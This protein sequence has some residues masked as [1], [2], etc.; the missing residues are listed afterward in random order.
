V[1]CGRCTRARDLYLSTA[2]TLSVVLCSND[3][4]ATEAPILSAPQMRPDQRPRARYRWKTLVSAVAAAGVVIAILWLARTS[5]M[6]HAGLAVLSESD[7][8]RI[9]LIDRQHAIVREGSVEL[10]VGDEDSIVDTPLGVVRAKNAKLRIAATPQ[11]ES[12]EPDQTQA[13]FIVTIAVTSGLARWSSKDEHDVAIGE[14]ETLVRPRPSSSPNPD[15]ESGALRTPQ[16]A[17]AARTSAV[18]TTNGLPIDIDPTLAAKIGYR[19]RGHVIDKSNGAPIDGAR[20]HFVTM[21]LPEGPWLEAQGR[22]EENGYFALRCSEVEESSLT[23]DR[24]IRANSN[25]PEGLDVE[26]DEYGSYRAPLDAPGLKLGSPFDFGAIALDRGLKLSGRIIDATGVPVAGAI[27]FAGHGGYASVW[28]TA[29]EVGNSDHAGQIMLR[30]RLSGYDGVVLVAV[31]DRGLGWME[32]PIRDGGSE[33]LDAVMQLQPTAKLV[34]CVRD[35]AGLPIA[36]AAVK[37]EP[38]FKPFD[39]FYRG[40]HTLDVEVIPVACSIFTGKT[41]GAGNLE[42]PFLPSPKEYSAYEIGVEHYGFTRSVR[43][44]DALDPTRTSRIEITMPEYRRFA[45]SGRVT[46][47]AGQPIAGARV[48]A[49]VTD[50]DGRYRVTNLDPSQR[51]VELTYS[52]NG[53]IPSTRRVAS[54]PKADIEGFDVVLDAPMSIDGHIVDE[55]GARVAGARVMLE[56]GRSW[57]RM[58]NRDERTDVDGNFSF[59]NSTAGEWNVVITG[60]SPEDAWARYDGPPVHGGD[61]GV[62]LVLH[63]A[64]T[65]AQEPGARVTAEI[66]DAETHQPIDPVHVAILSNAGDNPFPQP[67]PLG[68]EQKLGVVSIAYVPRGSWSL[69]ISA[70]AGRYASQCFTVEPARTEVSLTIVV[71]RPSSI[72]GTIMFGEFERSQP[73]TVWARLVPQHHSPDWLGMPKSYSFGEID[74]DAAFQFDNLVAGRWRISMISK[75][76]IAER[77]L[78]IVPGQTAEVELVCQPAAHI[79]FSSA[80]PSA[81]SVLEIHLSAQGGSGSLDVDD[82]EPAKN[83]H[84]TARISVCSGRYRWTATW[85]NEHDAGSSTQDILSQSG[86]V[87]VAAGAT[88]E[89]ELTVIHK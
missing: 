26:H 24:A 16:Q 60:P 1:R 12:V 75:D 13:A 27:L 83:G 38:K 57:V 3:P 17:D 34:V 22:S 72:R 39:H 40:T 76:L 69:W 33:W 77:E 23:G 65:A 6:R 53:F 2:D 51:Q 55:L 20:V 87:E 9:E 7:D 32:L 81:D 56:R 49:A 86:D 84:H 5:V 80:A 74:A 58:S 25:A 29:H 11:G 46:D 10:E 66:V 59:K 71:G 52:A 30:H 18:T 28:S 45:V 50:A 67:G 42:L 31:S 4:S 54:T 21:L 15:N 63:R 82:T 79:I 70:Q 8:A 73:A 78:D 68:L 62:E 19:I 61:R 44:V 89:I 64:K 41:D 35:E 47:V 14:G 85:R 36:G 48:G 37:V 88:R 43:S